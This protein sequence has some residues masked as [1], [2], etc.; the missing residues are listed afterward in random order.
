LIL[1]IGALLFDN[2]GVLVD[3]HAAA[4]KSWDQWSR[5]YSV[6]FNFEDNLGRRSADLVLALVGDEL[7]QAANDR[8][9]FLEQELAQQTVALPGA[10]E[11]LHSSPLDRWTICT[12]ANPRLGRARIEAAGLPVPRHLVSGE[13]VERGKPFPDPYLL[14]AK[15]LGFEPIDCVVFEDAPAGVQSAR[16]AGTGFVVGVSSKALNTEADVVVENLTGIRFDGFVLTIP[17]DVRLR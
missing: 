4:K 17:E 11:L 1:K 9:D 16:A 5:E 14:G 13:D 3:S 10:H 8:I 2:D 6:N 15:K 12:S 7:F